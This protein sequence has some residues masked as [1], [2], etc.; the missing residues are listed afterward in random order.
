MTAGPHT[1]VVSRA[2]PAEAPAHPATLLLVDAEAGRRNRR[3]IDAVLL[4]VAAFLVVLQAA[5]AT[6][7]ETSDADV[8]HS[9]MTLLGWAPAVWRVAFAGL[10]I[11][12]VVVAADVLL[13][14]RWLLAR[15]MALAIF[16]VVAL[17]FILG[18]IVE[19]HWLVA[20]AGLLRRWGFPELRLACAIAILAVTAPELQRAVRLLGGWL[21][22]LAVVG[23]VVLG[24]AR[25]SSAL[26]AVAVG[27]GT[28]A[29][30]SL[31]LGTARGVPPS[32][33][34]RGALASLGVELNR[35]ALSARQHVGAVEYVGE[36]ADGRPVRARVLGRDAQDTQR[37]VRR[38]REMAYR[39]PPRSVPI[40][41]LE[42]VEHEALAIFMAA[43]AGA[44]VPEVVTAALGPDGDAIV[45]TR[46]PDVEPLEQAP[47]EDVSDATLTGLWEEVAKLHAAGIS[48]GR[49]NLSNVVLV[50]GEPGLR[51]LAA[52]TLGAPQSALDIDVAELLVACTV[53]V[54][55][56]R[57][58]R[59]AVAG[60]G[61]DAVKG[62]L[63]YLQRAALSP[64]V[65]D[66]A[67]THEV[68]LKQ[69]RSDAA[70][71]VGAEKP[72][73]LAPLRRVTLRS[74]LTT[75]ALAVAA[76]LI[77]T[78]LAQIGFHQIVRELRSADV[79]WLALALV[80]AQLP[81]LGGA[82][83]LRGSVLT[84]LPLRP[85]V[86]LHSAIKFVNATVPSDA[87]K[88]AI[89]TRFLERMGTPLPA[90]VVSG[91]VASAASTIVQVLLVVVTLPLIHI[92]TAKLG[93]GTPSTRLIVA[94]LLALTATGVIVLAVPKVRV[95]VVPVVQTALR[96][97]REVARMRRKRLELFGGNLVGELFYALALGAVCLAYGIHLTLA[98]LLFANTA[99]SALSGLIP[100]PGGVGAAEATLTACLSALG[101]DTSTAF[102]IAFTHRLCTYYLPP[103][104][105][106]ASLKWLERKGYV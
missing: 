23:S 72:P 78:Q 57:A 105:G 15:D 27:L 16:L 96:N 1:D 104:W 71:A 24:A 47:S 40:G 22:P 93:V 77:I 5:V 39:D 49:L 14:R 17:G 58:L 74:A 81:Y 54:G 33:R 61:V 92:D 50:D 86:V 37:L 100:T 55:P 34:V 53:L 67:H 18:R 20:K 13:R 70:T 35:L 69:L 52:A 64:H 42:Q 3:T 91:A 63:P 101:V 88:I 21:I 26:A 83:S 10:L 89:S 32:A 85:T 95:K 102:A 82:I 62:A 75:A 11:L 51:G 29:L 66:L 65:R 98:E 12:A 97:V 80:L 68:A 44:M 19:S 7:A 79:A 36:D 25:P 103:F 48:H 46:E 87:G 9:L 99:A 2:E 30:V 45:L 4:A 28:G 90:A 38:W 59:T 106:Y 6:Y 84:P 94:V 43:Q 31:V 41:R 8:A 76:Y 73:E 56:E 60:I